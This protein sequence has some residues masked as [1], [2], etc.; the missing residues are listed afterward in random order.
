MN[1]GLV[2]GEKVGSGVPTNMRETVSFCLCQMV[3]GAF[4]GAKVGE[5]VGPILEME[6]PEPT[7]L[8]HCLGSS[9]NVRVRMCTHPECDGCPPVLRASKCAPKTTL[10]VA[11]AVFMTSGDG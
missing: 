5:A 9:G 3:V 6:K 1:V 10:V 8:A 2:V 7:C 4:D 11:R